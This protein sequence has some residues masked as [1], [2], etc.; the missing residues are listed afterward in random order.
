MN[1]KKYIYKQIK[2]KSIKLET[3]HIYKNNLITFYFIL[4]KL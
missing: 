3:N 2:F 1:S 4:E